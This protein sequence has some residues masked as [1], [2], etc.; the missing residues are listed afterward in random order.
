MLW[1]FSIW[2]ESVAILPQLFMLQRTGSAETITTHYLFALGAYRALYIPNWIWRCVVTFL[3]SVLYSAKRPHRRSQGADAFSLSQ[4]R[5]RRLLRPD[6]RARRPRPDRPLHR[7]LLHLLDQ[8]HAG[9]AVQPAR[10]KITIPLRNNEGNGGGSS[11]RAGN[12][13][14]FTSFTDTWTKERGR[15]NLSRRVNVGISI[16]AG[17]VCITI[18]AFAQKVGRS[19]RGAFRSCDIT[20][21]GGLGRGE[22]AIGIRA[23]HSHVSLP[24]TLLH[25]RGSVVASRNQ[26]VLLVIKTE[27]MPCS[28]FEG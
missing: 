26:K 18:A 6:P 23:R 13:P 5:H 22:R 2:L 25:D 12:A 14:F 28:H 1:A 21:S 16:A 3:F 8:D 15:H 20:L 11:S 10:V 17:V 24:A 7:L 27:P 4:I 19:F 9:Q